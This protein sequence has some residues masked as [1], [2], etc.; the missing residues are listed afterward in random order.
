MSIFDLRIRA[1]RSGRPAAPLHRP[2]HEGDG[3][4]P[5]RGRRVGPVEDRRP[6][7]SRHGTTG[8]TF[9]GTGEGACPPLDTFGAAFPEARKSTL[10]KLLRE[11]FP[12][13]RVDA[14]QERGEDLALGF[15]ELGDALLR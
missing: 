4:V 2:R 8:C 11:P 10:F 5:G 14:G 15:D 3:E 12:A 1:P 6:R 13:H 7:L 9:G